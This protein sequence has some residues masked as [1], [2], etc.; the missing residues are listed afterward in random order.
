MRKKTAFTIYRDKHA[1]LRYLKDRII[2]VIGYG[3]QGRTQAKNLRDSGLDVI[4]GLPKGSKSKRLARQ[5]GFEVYSTEKAIQLGNLFAA[6]YIKAPLQDRHANIQTYD[7][8]LKLVR[9]GI[10]YP[11]FEALREALR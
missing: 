8:M 6:L 4:I 5:D 10:T 7:K 1:N 2:A 3:K 11:S 9:S